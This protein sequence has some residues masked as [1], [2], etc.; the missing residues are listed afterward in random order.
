[1]CGKQDQDSAGKGVS[2]RV[3]EGEGAGGVLRWID[4]RVS[5]SSRQTGAAGG[6]R[7]MP[8]MLLL[9]PQVQAVFA[10]VD[11]APQS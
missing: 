5:S 4:V 11:C 1:M 3:G 6:G 10:L 7:G 9:L 8:Q 2:A